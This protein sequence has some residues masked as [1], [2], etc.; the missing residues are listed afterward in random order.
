MRSKFVL[1]PYTSPTPQVF[2]KAE[3][4]PRTCAVLVFNTQRQ[5]LDETVS[6]AHASAAAGIQQA[7]RTS[8]TL[9]SPSKRHWDRF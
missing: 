3:A 9:P 8:A 2:H 1:A 5:G 6:Q 7:L 4:A